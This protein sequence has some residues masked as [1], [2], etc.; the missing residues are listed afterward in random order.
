MNTLIYIFPQFF[1]VFQMFGRFVTS[2]LKCCL[3]CTFISL[4]SANS[5]FSLNS[6]NYQKNRMTVVRNR[7][8]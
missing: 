3:S 1:E 2:S 6:F 8:I 4:G 5:S 7:E